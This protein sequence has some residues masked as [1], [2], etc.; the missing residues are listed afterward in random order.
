MWPLQPEPAPKPE[1]TPRVEPTLRTESAP[2]PQRPPTG[3]EEP[4]HWPGESRTAGDDCTRI[5]AG[6]AA[7]GAQ[8]APRR[9][10]R[11][12][13]RRALAH[14][15]RSR[16]RWPRAA[17]ASAPRA[18]AFA[19]GIAGGPHTRCPAR[20]GARRSKS[21]RDGATAGGRATSFAQVRGQ[22]RRRAAWRAR[23]SQ[24]GAG[25]T[26]PG[27][28]RA[29]SRLAAGGCVAPPIPDRRCP[30]QPVRTENDRR[31]RRTGHG[32]VYA[33][34]VVAPVRRHAAPPVPDR[35]CPLAAPGTARGGR[36]GR[37]RG[38]RGCGPSSARR[39]S[40]PTSPD[41]PDTTAS[42]DG[43]P[44]PQKS[45]Y[46]SLEQEMASLLNRPPSKP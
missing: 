17:S 27:G 24:A 5:T 39:R 19:A 36:T 38:D 37:E 4:I 13:G 44:A 21:V 42:P 16:A 15:A 40:L 25:R 1:A 10:A 28:F 22:V 20:T 18:A 3:L 32:R 34:A 11:G 43:K 30:R 29:V 31:A 41:A 8:T 9:S 7:A 6:A 46:D 12:L 45:M 33:R 2:R 23:C 35:R 14:P 26:G